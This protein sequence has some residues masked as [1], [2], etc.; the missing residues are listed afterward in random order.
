MKRSQINQAI[1]TAEALL[2]ELAWRLPDF[3]S[4]S[5]DEHARLAERSQWLSARQM[6]WDVTDFG[7]GDFAAKG[8][9]LFCL[10]NGLA[11]QPGE[12]PYA[13]KLLFVRPGQETPFH[14]HHDKLEDIIV[15]GGGTLC[16]EFTARG[17][18]RDDAPLT[19]DAITRVDGRAVPLYQGPIRL[20]AGQSITIP[21]G[22]Q[23]R[24]WGEGEMVLAAEVSQCND[25][26]DNHFLDGLGRFSAIDEDAPVHRLLWNEGGAT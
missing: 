2:V 26:R 8:L 22:V 10:R 21:R 7:Q 6:G 4:W 15:R 24:F 25:H 23:H 19:D 17:A 3:A 5:R 1:Q 20:S 9:T 14:A 12:R 18:V 13:E 16:V 11:D